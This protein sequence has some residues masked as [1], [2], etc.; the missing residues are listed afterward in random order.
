MDMCQSVLTEFITTAYISTIACL[1]YGKMIGSYV[2][3]MNIVIYLVNFPELNRVVS[4][5]TN[6]LQTMVSQCCSCYGH[7]AYSLKPDLG[8]S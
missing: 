4:H 3:C 8:L 6:F 7:A 5:F 2:F 1:K